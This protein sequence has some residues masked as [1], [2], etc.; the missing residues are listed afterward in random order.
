MVQLAKEGLVVLMNEPNDK[1]PLAVLR[2][3][4]L[5][6]YLNRLFGPITEWQR[7][8][9]RFIRLIVNFPVKILTDSI[10]RPL[11]ELLRL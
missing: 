2:R 11:A 5:L 7:Q 3:R 9:E 1:L 6:Q 10:K 4:Q 8:G